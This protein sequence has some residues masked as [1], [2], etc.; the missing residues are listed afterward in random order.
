MGAGFYIS[1]TGPAAN[2]SF[3]DSELLALLERQSVVGDNQMM[4][5]RDGKIQRRGCL[6]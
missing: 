2:E 4:P 1:M 5:I 3:A 6:N